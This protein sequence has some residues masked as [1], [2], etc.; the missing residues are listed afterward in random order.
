M[1]CSRNR[2]HSARASANRCPV[3]SDALMAGQV[4]AS[5]SGLSIESL[6]LREMRFNVRFKAT[7]RGH[8][9]KWPCP[10]AGRRQQGCRGLRASSVVGTWPESI[11][12]RGFVMPGLLDQERQVHQVFHACVLPAFPW[13]SVG[14]NLPSE[15]FLGRNG[16]TV[17]AVSEFVTSKEVINTLQG[18]GIQPQAA[19]DSRGT[20]HL[21]YYKG[22]N[23]KGDESFAEV[24]RGAEFVADVGHKIAPRK[25]ERAAKTS[26]IGNPASRAAVGLNPRRSG[27]RPRGRCRDG[28]PRRRVFRGGGAC[29]YQ[30]C[31]CRWWRR[32]PRHPGAGVPG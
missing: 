10:R 13:Q 19:V 20:V 12:S 18:G 29:G 1:F 5:D 15:L 9:C 30:R 24:E 11:H 14:M 2:S 8:L 17:P 21:I 26:H 4:D 16:G 7:L 23:T 3:E 6:N 22:D 31:G 28:G 32:I 25:V 27:S